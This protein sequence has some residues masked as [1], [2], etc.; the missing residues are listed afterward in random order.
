MRR[1]FLLSTCVLLVAAC[2]NGGG[3]ASGSDAG[4]ADAGARADLGSPTD[5]G[6]PADLAHADLGS[7]DL[8]SVD[9][10][11]LEGV[12]LG[13]MDFGVMDLG[14]L[15]LGASDAGPADLGLLSDAFASCTS[16]TECDD[17]NMCNGTEVCTANVCVAGPTLSCDDSNSCTDD[18]CNPSSGCSHET[19]PDLTTCDDGRACTLTDRCSSGVCGGRARRCLSGCICIEPSGVCSGPSCELTPE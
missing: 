16:S 18:F 19:L 10:G 8:G 14:A 3:I 11:A 12:D 15:D 5:S 2:A 17:A 13:A 4:N 9:L 1:V 7:V 6:A